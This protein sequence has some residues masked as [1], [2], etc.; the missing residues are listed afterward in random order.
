[1]LTFSQ[2]YDLDA[3]LATSKISLHHDVPT[4]KHQS[5]LFSH[6]VARVEDEEVADVYNLAHILFDDYDDEFTLGLSGPLQKTYAHRIRRDRLAK[7]LSQKILAGLAD[8]LA[9]LEQISPIK[10]AIFRLTAYDIKGACELLKKSKSPRLMLLVSQLKG[11]DSA[12][13]NGM[14]SQIDAWRE[15]KSLSEIDLEIR[16]LYELLAGNVA[17]S[18][19]REGKGVAVEDRAETFTI[20]TRYNL[21]WLQVF[22]LG[23]FYGR[24]EK[25]GGEGISTIESAVREY[26]AR[27]DCGEESV[28]PL[29][30]DVAWSLIKLYASKHD[31]QKEVQAPEFP[32]ALEGL[33][34]QFDHSALFNFFEAMKAS[35]KVKLDT[36][37]TDELAETLAAEL[38]AQG[39]LASAVYSLSHLSSTRAKKI[40]IQSLIDQFAATLPGPDTATSD[41]G[42]ALWQRLTIDLKVPTSWIYMSKARFAASATNKGGDNTSE[43]RY[44]VA[45]EA[46]DEA[47]ECL[48]KRVAP[49][50]IIDEDYRGLLGLCSLFGD[51]PARR[52]SNWYDGGEIFETFSKL[53]TGMIDKKDA[54][55][56]AN[57]RKKLIRM[58]NQHSRGQTLKLSQLSQHEL[59]EHVAGREMANSLAKLFQSGGAIGSVEEI[60]QLP[61]TEDVRL[62]I[63]SAAGMLRDASEKEKGANRNKTSGLGLTQIANEDIMDEDD[64]EQNGTG[65]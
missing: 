29:E 18:L 57:L 50:L 62:Q 25:S 23:L 63:R 64:G 36:T 17:I 15:Q 41:S 28:K 55:A 45:A 54:G 12:F 59:E 39:D 43:L 31:P 34:K 4:V 13:M 22:A 1:M 30:N 11:A 6:L 32:A 58:N 27:C 40:L 52:V 56:I 8:E 61:L 21:T 7:Y 19:G 48:L 9:Q 46:W 60:L 10:A 33:K 65:A 47:H 3:A 26:Q 24:E 2:P 35:L 37:K 14:R 42:I 38:S 5:V 53:M 44:L 51:D 20:S 16:T 49:A